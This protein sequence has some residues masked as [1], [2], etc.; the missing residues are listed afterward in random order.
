MQI[1]IPA[2]FERTSSRQ[3]AEFV[4]NLLGLRPL[5]MKM[6]LEPQTDGAE[7]FRRDRD[8][9]IVE[10]EKLERERSREP[11]WKLLNGEGL[12]NGSSNR[13]LQKMPSEELKVLLSSGASIRRI[14]SED[15]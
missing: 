1:H 8:A 15:L 9:G 2:K 4:V 14:T 6:F 7:K 10:R 12:V 13:R 5:V 11:Q 3:T